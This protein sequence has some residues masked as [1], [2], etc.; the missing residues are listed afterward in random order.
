[1]TGPEWNDLIQ[2]CVKPL[3]LDVELAVRTDGHYVYV[4]EKPVGSKKPITEIRIAENEFE[5]RNE[6][7]I[8]ELLERK[9]KAINIS[10]E[11]EPVKT[12]PKPTHV[13]GS[14]RPEEQNRLRELLAS[15]NHPNN[16]AINQEKK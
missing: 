7:G 5:G 12:T 11:K 1:M 2:Q 8:R 16:L 14:L 13:D 6:L 10:V 3:N 4:G 9:L 15:R